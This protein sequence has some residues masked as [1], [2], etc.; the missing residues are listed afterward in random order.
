MTLH[1]VTLHHRTVPGILI[2]IGGEVHA[3]G[4]VGKKCVL[5][6]H[7][8]IQSGKG[9]LACS[10]AVHHVQKFPRIGHIESLFVKLLIFPLGEHENVRFNRFQTVASGFPE[11]S[12]DK[13]RYITTVAVY[14]G[15]AH[16]KL[17]RIDH[18]S[19]KFFI[20]VIQVRHIAPIGS[21]GHLQISQRIQIVVVFVILR[22]H[23]IECGV[24]GYP[25]QNDLHIQFVSLVDQ[26]FQV[27]HSSEF[28]INGLVILHR[29]ITTLS[30]FSVYLTDGMNRHQPHDFNAHIFKSRQ[31]FRK[32]IQRTFRCM[33]PDVCFVDRSVF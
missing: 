14:I 28:G 16:P 12:R 5:L 30:A 10:N 2:V 33:L 26:T 27:F 13:S 1:A 24:V 3:V 19:P 32:C 22:P 20:L 29:I 7:V 18:L 11:I 6:S 17:Q 23:V 4:V 21:F 8:L 15:F 25:I 31:V 9:F